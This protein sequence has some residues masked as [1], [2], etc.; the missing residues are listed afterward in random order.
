MVML[1]NLATIMLE[2]GHHGATGG[3]SYI[4]KFI[5][6]EE[7]E[8]NLHPKLQSKLADLFA[9]V[10]QDDSY[11]FLIETH[12]EYVVRR[13]Q[14]IVAQLGAADEKELEKQNPFKV[15]Y[16]P[17]D[18][19]PYDMK[20][21]MSGRFENKFGNGFFD[22]ASNSALTISKLERKKANV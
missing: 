16:F 17:E 4:P 12:S 13:T 1:F 21:L 7:P 3:K 19:T 9:E 22:E 8:Q 11:K 18:G 5:I 10:A 6:I 14:V 2:E 20:Y 15:Y